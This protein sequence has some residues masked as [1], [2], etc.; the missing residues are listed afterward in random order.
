MHRTAATAALMALMTI[1]AHAR[2]PL[3]EDRILTYRCELDLIDRQW[4]PPLALDFSNQLVAFDD[5]VATDGYTVDDNPSSVKFDVYDDVNK[6]RYTVVVGEII[7]VR[8]QDEVSVQLMI[9]RDRRNTDGLFH[10]SIL[11]KC[12]SR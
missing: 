11:G 8:W 3:E 1:P 7:G 9:Q 12:Q 4:T 10:T 2:A 5:K 6:L